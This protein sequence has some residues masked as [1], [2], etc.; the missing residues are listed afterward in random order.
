[1]ATLHPWL[2]TRPHT[3]SVAFGREIIDEDDTTSLENFTDG[4]ETV[5]KRRSLSIEASP[6]SPVVHTQHG[7][8]S[9]LGD[10][11]NPSTPLPK[12]RKLCA[13]SNLKI[14]DAVDIS[15]SSEAEESPGSDS[16][17]H[18]REEDEERT[19]IDD[20][21]LRSSPELVTPT[22]PTRF[23]I[24]LTKTD[25]MQSAQQRSAFRPFAKDSHLNAVAEHALPDAFSP[26]R[27]KGQKSYT[28]GGLADAVRNWVLNVAAEE[29]Q[30]KRAEET[31][32]LES[33]VMDRSGRAIVANDDNGNRWI[34]VGD[35]PSGRCWRLY[36]YFISTP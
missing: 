5:P 22:M 16:N 29:S 7:A 1:M 21:K 10:Y 14:R 36:I 15:S 26:S 8:S 18:Q 27:R 11:V 34:L 25:T 28:P 12:R 32:N 17:D 33:A 35:Q 30:L 9:D 20:D 2:S 13:S 31:V 24:P 6:K 23:K 3:S 19:R 4:L